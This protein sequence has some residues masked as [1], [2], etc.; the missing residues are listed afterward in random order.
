MWFKLAKER[1]GL[2]NWPSHEPLGTGREACFSEEGE[3][4]LSL[5]E[6]FAAEKH[7]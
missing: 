6:P 4:P 1:V 7:F 5:A 3:V 2:E